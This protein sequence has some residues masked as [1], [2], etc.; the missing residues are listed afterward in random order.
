MLLDLHEIELGL[1]R[2]SSDAPPD[3][4]GLRLRKPGLAE[5]AVRRIEKVVGDALPPKF[6][7]L[8]RDYDFGNLFIGWVTFGTTGDYETELLE[9]SDHPHVRLVVAT[10]E[11]YVVA[12]DVRTGAVEAVAYENGWNGATTRVAQDFELFV[13][14]VGSLYLLI[15]SVMDKR[16]FVAQVAVQVGASLDSTFW[17]QPLNDIGL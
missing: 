1:E 7:V 3:L 15:P 14:G 8:I 11:A 6:R 10:T 13:R 2:I 4:T 12:L 5:P 9:R 16:D 17:M